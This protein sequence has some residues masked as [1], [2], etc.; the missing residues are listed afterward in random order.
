MMRK[1]RIVSLAMQISADGY[2][3]RSN[4][5]I[6]WIHGDLTP[7]LIAAT[8]SYLEHID[9]M[10]MGRVTYEEQYAYWP[11]ADDPLASVVNGHEKLVFSRTLSDAKWQR[12]RIASTSPAEEIAALRERS[13]GTIG[14]TGGSDF[15]ASMLHESLVDEL[16]LTV[17]PTALGSG[18]KLFPEPQRLEFISSDRFQTGALVNTYRVVK[19]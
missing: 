4:G 9:T 6:D 12:S 3:A 2:I 5:R 18:K 8:K 14:V 11:T 10:L 15:I 17:H 7:D 1:V 16:R 19:E 13:G